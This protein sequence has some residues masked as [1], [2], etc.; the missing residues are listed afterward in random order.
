MKLTILGTGN[1]TVSEC[2]NTCY[3]IRTIEGKHFLVDAGG[4]NRIL[5]VLKT[6][7]ST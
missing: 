4:G 1:A 3:A 5:K 6:Q 7:E 2:Y